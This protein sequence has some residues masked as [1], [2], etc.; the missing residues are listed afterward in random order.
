MMLHFNTCLKPAKGDT[1][2]RPRLASM[3]RQNASSAYWHAPKAQP[4]FGLAHGRRKTADFFSAPPFGGGK[5]AE[6]SPVCHFSGDG[7]PT[8]A[9]R[10]HFPSSNPLC[11]IPTDRA[12]FYTREDIT[13]HLFCKSC[14]TVTILFVM[15]NNKFNRLLQGLKVAEVAGLAHTVCGIY[16]SRSTEL[17]ADVYLRNVM[18]DLRGLSDRILDALRNNRLISSLETFDAHRMRCVSALVNLKKGYDKLPNEYIQSHWT[19]LKPVFETYLSA[20]QAGNY[21]SKTAL[22][23]S[24]LL[25]LSAGDL[26]VHLDELDTMKTAVD[27]LRDAESSFETK[28]LEYQQRILEDKTESATDL[29]EE[30]VELI[31]QKLVVHLEAKCNED[32]ATYGP[33]AKLVDA[34][35]RAENAKLRRRKGRKETPSVIPST[36]PV[37]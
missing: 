12:R 14:R 2:S 16:E 23:Q 7:K 30:I 4:A 35:I 31:N 36:E 11:V 28:L 17:S 22:I 5:W 9:L 33:F 13:F 19:A 34:Q 8:N 3:G 32:A 6:K 24:L 26:T 1:P 37:G 21:Q 25:R 20:I 29:K 15:Y 27:Q 10:G 18:T